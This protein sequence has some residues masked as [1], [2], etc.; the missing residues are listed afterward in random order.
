MAITCRGKNTMR[1]VDFENMRMEHIRESGGNLLRLTLGYYEPSTAL[2]RLI[3]NLH[4]KDIIHDGLA[5]SLISGNPGH[6]IKGIMFENLVIHG[7]RIN[8]VKQVKITIGD[9]VS[10]VFFK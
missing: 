2:A 8:D 5:G 10:G 9:N 3:E 4:F 1:N 7:E 6:P